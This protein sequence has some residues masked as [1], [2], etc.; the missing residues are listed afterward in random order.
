MFTDFNSLSHEAQLSQ[1][2]GYLQSLFGSG[3]MLFGVFHRIYCLL[4]IAQFE[5]ITQMTFFFLAQG[6][7]F[8]G[9]SLPIQ[10]VQFGFSEIIDARH[11]R[12]TPFTE[13]IVV[14]L[15]PILVFIPIIRFFV[16]IK[17]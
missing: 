2:A 6:K 13:L 10:H 8:F 9:A 7:I 15:V 5:G 16:L 1:A 3:Q 11:N 17:F 4:E 12:K 14:F